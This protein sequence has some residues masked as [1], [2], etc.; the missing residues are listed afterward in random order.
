MLALPFIVEAECIVH[1]YQNCV[2]TALGHVV[3]SFTY[4]NQLYSILGIAII[5]IKLLG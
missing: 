4:F 5:S 2:Y 1:D 3:Q